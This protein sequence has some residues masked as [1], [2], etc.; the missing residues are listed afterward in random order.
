MASSVKII[1]QSVNYHHFACLLTGSLT[2]PWIPIT[3]GPKLCGPSKTFRLTS[4]ATSDCTKP[5]APCTIDPS[6]PLPPTLLGFPLSLPLDRLAD[7]PQVYSDPRFP[8]ASPLRSVVPRECTMSTSPL[9]RSHSWAV[10]SPRPV[11]LS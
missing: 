7:I 1:S 9:C 6:G 3:Q 2:L 5:L 10:S 11:L 4:L 8:Y